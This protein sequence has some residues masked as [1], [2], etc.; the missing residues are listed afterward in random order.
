M[1]KRR[2]Q[3]CEKIGRHMSAQCSDDIYNTRS[4]VVSLK[5]CYAH[6]VELFK[7]GQT[8]FVLKYGAGIMHGSSVELETDTQRN[9]FDFNSFR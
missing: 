5:L 9:Y 3:A 7:I 6:S 2:C 8:N 4:S 1:S